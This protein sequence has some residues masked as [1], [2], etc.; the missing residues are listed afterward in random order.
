MKRKLFSLLA[1][2]L[3]LALL[4]AQPGEGYYDDA[5]GKSGEALRTALYGIIHNHT[6]VGYDG[7]WDVYEDSDVKP[8]GTVWDMYS[9][10]PGGTPPYVFYPGEG[11]C[12]N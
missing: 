1:S 12:G 7:L 11:K 5:E 3:P 9:D 6:N 4:W 8:D 2:V 10:I